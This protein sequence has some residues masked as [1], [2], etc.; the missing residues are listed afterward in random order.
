MMTISLR[1]LH[2][3]PAHAVGSYVATVVWQPVGCLAASSCYSCSY[4]FLRMSSCIDNILCL[5]LQA[6]GSD[7]SGYTTIATGHLFVL[8]RHS[9]VIFS[10]GGL[11]NL[12]CSDLVCYVLFIYFVGHL[13][14][15]KNLSR[16][17]KYE[18]IKVMVA[19]MC[20]MS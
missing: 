9:L 13:R 5:P 2:S 15:N 19:V 3:A 17:F 11:S 12:L 18:D 7:A 16:C 1:N 4:E 8:Q 20:I 6:A 10:C 14:Y